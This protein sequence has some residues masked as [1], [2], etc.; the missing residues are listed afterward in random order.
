MEDED[1]ERYA[2]TLSLGVERLMNEVLSGAHTARVR[3]D[4]RSGA[5]NG[6]NGTPTFFINGVRYEGIPEVEPLF[7]ALSGQ[8]I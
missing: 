6:V 4:F 3:E 2:L 7:A 5:R 8:P 1:L